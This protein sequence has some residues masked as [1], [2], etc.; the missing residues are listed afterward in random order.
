MISIGEYFGPWLNH[1]DATR[2]RKQH[3]E[4]LLDACA[5]LESY[6]IADGVAFP[7]NPATGSGVSG[8]TYGG[9]RPQSCTQG[10]A[11]SN[12]KEGLAV[13]RFDPLGK[14]DAWCLANLDKLAECCIW[15]ESPDDTEHWSHWQCVP[16][17]SG[18]RVFNP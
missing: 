3:A 2:D 17:G 15:I 7:L 11:H 5:R 6:A 8:K 9:F 16:P 18:H 1:P 14:I 10:S 13:D 4:R 12:H